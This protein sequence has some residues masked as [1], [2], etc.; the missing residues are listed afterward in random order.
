MGR[1]KSQQE[2]IDF[3]V[4]LAKDGWTKYGVYASVTIGQALGE[5][6]W[7]MSQPSAYQDNNLFGIKMSGSCPP[8]MNIT[9]GT[10]PLD[11]GAFRRY[12]SL[13]DSVE[14]HGHFLRNNSIYAKAFEVSN[15]YDQLKVI[16]DVGYCAGGGYYEHISSIMK[17]NNLTQYDV[18]T[19]GGTGSTSSSSSSAFT[20]Y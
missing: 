6:G 4:P 2:F 9:Q 7:E 14:D 17:K 8:G 13:E 19:P 5:A 10:K 12:E 16:A 3:L 1:F 15:P 11:G 18:D 20:K